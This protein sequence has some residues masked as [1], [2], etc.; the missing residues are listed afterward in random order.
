MKNDLVETPNAPSE[1]VSPQPDPIP[2]EEEESSPEEQP[3]P[4]KAQFGSFV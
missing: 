4:F 2:H 3:A 1:D